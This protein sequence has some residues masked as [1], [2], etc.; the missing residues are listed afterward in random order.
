MLGESLEDF[1]LAVYAI[2]GED[3]ADSKEVAEKMY[4]K[5]S[6][7]QLSA[8]KLRQLGLIEDKD[9]VQFVKLTP[10]GLDIAMGINR[11][12]DAIKDFLTDFLCVPPQTADEDAHHLEHVISDYSLDRIIAF[13]E[14]VKSTPSE[15]KKWMDDFKNH[16][17]SLP[18]KR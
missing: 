13:L 3:W 14:F 12:H 4:V 2:A 5:L 15:H 9:H 11:K 17:C 1:L 8:G 18:I 6:S 7:A 10:T 16:A